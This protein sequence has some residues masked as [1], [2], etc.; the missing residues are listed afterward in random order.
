MTASE[1]LIAEAS[2]GVILPS[3]VGGGTDSCPRPWG[4]LSM[5]ELERGESGIKSSDSNK[6]AKLQGPLGVLPEKED[7][8]RWWSTIGALGATAG[9]V[10]AG[11]VNVSAGAPTVAGGGADWPWGRA[12][13]SSTTAVAINSAAAAASEALICLPAEV[14]TVESDV[15]MVTVVVAAELLVVVGV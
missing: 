11:V 14:V 2:S 7:M 1:L 12:K 3:S 10:M 15:V 4:R 8:G 13:M 9:M 5:D 6:E